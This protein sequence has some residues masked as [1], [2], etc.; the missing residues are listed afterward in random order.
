MLT[1]AGSV[2]ANSVN[3]TTTYQIGGSNILSTAGRQNL[4]LGQQAGQNN[5]SD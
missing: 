4:F 3:A 1:V 2:S 5:T